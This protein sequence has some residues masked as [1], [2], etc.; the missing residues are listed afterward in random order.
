VYHCITFKSGLVLLTHVVDAVLH[1]KALYILGSLLALTQTS[2]H[3]S[4]DGLLL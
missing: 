3:F 4:K 1:P 2:Q